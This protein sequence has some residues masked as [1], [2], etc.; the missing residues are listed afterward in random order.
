MAKAS[1]GWGTENEQKDT[2]STK[3]GGGEKK[4]G[5]GKR[6]FVEG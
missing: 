4:M 2:K 6:I 1:H 5:T 3:V